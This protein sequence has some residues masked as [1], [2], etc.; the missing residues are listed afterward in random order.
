MLSAAL[1]GP[2]SKPG[3]PGILLAPPPTS[4]GKIRIP[5]PPP[6]NDPATVR[7][8]SGRSAG[9]KDSKG[10]GSHSDPLSDLSSIGKNLPSTTGSASSKNTASGWAAF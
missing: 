3:K 1:S 4:S 7:I 6:P 8:T 10:S 9:L 2:A 5:L